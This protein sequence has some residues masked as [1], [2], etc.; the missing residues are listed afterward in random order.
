MPNS[1]NDAV[2]NGST[3]TQVQT[4]TSNLPPN[5]S[6]AI[7]RFLADAE[8]KCPLGLN[9]VQSAAEVE[10]AAKARMSAKLQAFEQQFQSQR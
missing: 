5:H 1:S 9:T 4:P 2:Y 7:G 3:S 8:Q 6:F 10:A